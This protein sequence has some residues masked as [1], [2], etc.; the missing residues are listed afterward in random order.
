MPDKIVNLIKKYRITH[1]E[2]IGVI[3]VRSTCYKSLNQLV[4]Y[5]G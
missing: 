2:R 3:V 1:L 4:P 5:A